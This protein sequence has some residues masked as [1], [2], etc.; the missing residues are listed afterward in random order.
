MQLRLSLT[1]LD[2]RFTYLMNGKPY[3]GEAVNPKGLSVWERMMGFSKVCSTCA[4]HCGFCCSLLYQ[5]TALSNRLSRGDEQTACVK[6][7]RPVPESARQGKGL[8]T[9]TCIQ[10]MRQPAWLW[11]LWAPASTPHGFCAN[12]EL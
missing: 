4:A 12:A 11:W 1:E 5:S 6:C 2:R 3:H 8:L 9:P 10:Q 7:L